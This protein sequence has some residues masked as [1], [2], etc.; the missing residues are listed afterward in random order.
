MINIP[1]SR[2]ITTE[3]AL[4]LIK[5]QGNKITAVIYPQ[6]TLMF[7]MCLLVY[8]SCLFIRYDTDL[9]NHYSQNYS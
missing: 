1:A 5:R 7:F 3:Q 4:K 6:Q 2:E 9:I 8:L